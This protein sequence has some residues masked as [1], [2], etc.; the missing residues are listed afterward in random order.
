MF[1]P[2]ERGVR[3]IILYSRGMFCVNLMSLNFPR[4]GGGPPPN[5]QPLDPHMWY[6]QP[7]L[8]IHRT[9]RQHNTATP[10]PKSGR[11]FHWQ[12]R[13]QHFMSKTERILISKRGNRNVYFLCDEVLGLLSKLK[14]VWFLTYCVRTIANPNTNIQRNTRDTCGLLRCILNL[15]YLYKEFVVSRQY[16]KCG[17]IHVPLHDYQDVEMKIFEKRVDL[18][19][20][21]M[22]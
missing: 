5:P 10:R 15:L 22:I 13:L 17:N 1:S 6:L 2:G 18:V 11:A 12:H 4:G 3:G 20:L 9:N 7:E 14:S 19:S 16:N 21:H 8:T